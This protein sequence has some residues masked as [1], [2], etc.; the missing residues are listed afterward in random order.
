MTEIMVD[1]E[2]L[3]NKENKLIVQ[4]GACFFDRKTGDIGRTFKINIDAISAENAGLQ[5]DAKTV[6]WW[7]AQ[8]D[9]ARQSIIAEPR[10]EIREALKQ[11]S[12]FCVGVKAVWSH[13]TFDFVAIMQ[14]YQ[15]LNMPP[16]FSYKA[17]RDIRTL[18]D[19]YKV[20]V[21][22]ANRQGTHHDGLDDALHQVKYCM[23]A[24]K[25]IQELEQAKQL[26]S[27]IKSKKE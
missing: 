17:A 14:T 20:T 3:G 4:I 27:Y 5:L 15:K 13:A 1:L 11:F 19:L 22:G 26:I 25:K 9:A 8:S 18:T 10:V 16:P 7:L 23:E 6:Y 2:T 12:E 24:F 21:D